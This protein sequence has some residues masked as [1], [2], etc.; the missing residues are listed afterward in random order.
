M[1]DLSVTGLGPNRCFIDDDGIVIIDLA[2]EYNEEISRITNKVAKNTASR[3]LSEGKPALVIADFQHVTAITPG[4]RRSASQEGKS[5]GFDRT[6]IV[7]RRV[8][9]KYLFNLVLHLAN[10]S[11]VRFFSTKAAARKWLLSYQP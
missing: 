2:G 3:L 4:A 8:W 9:I 5:L 6:A 7:S 10:S 1:E 11:K